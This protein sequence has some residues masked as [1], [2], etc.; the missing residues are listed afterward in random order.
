MKYRRI[1]QD[2]IKRYE[3]PFFS[4][5]VFSDRESIP[6]VTFCGIKDAFATRISRESAADLIKRKFRNH[7][8]RQIEKLNS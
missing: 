8:E 5:V 3:T 4:L 2:K 7:P 6:F 1:I